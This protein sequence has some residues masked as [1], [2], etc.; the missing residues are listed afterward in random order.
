MTMFSS[1]VH[2]IK[3]NPIHKKRVLS[4]MM[5][6]VKTRP[7]FWL[8][9]LQFMYVKKGR[10]AVIYRSVRKDIVPFN[11][12][13]IGSRSVIES[14]SVVNN[15]VGGV[16]IG[17]HTRVGLGNTI[18]G[19]VTI[20]NKVNLAQNVVLS[21]MNHNFEDV[22]QSIAEQG[23]NVKHIIIEDDVWVGANSVILAGVRIGQHAVIGAG[24]VVTKDIPAYSVVLGNPARVVK[25]YDVEKKQWIKISK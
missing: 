4:L 15:A 23:V 20:G 21:G 7:R 8:R 22:D 18:I 6:P 5:H 24:S 16:E 3:T 25:Q 1:I 19:P 14:Y 12:F 9:C 11:V 17:S 13:R 2:K 10:K